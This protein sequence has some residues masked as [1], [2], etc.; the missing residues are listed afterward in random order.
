MS[1]QF[2]TEAQRMQKLANMPISEMALP[3]M[4]R[5]AGTGGAYT[6]TEKGEEILKQAKAT[7]KAPEGIKNSEIAALVFLFK[8]KKEGK[9]VQKMDYAKEKG[10]DQPAVNST[11][12]GL[13]MKEL[14][15]KEGYT[16][17]QQEPKTS[18]PRTDIS[19]ALSDLDI[20][21]SKKTLSED[22]EDFDLNAAFKSSPASHSYNDVLN[23]FT[24]YEDEDILNDFKAKFPKDKNINKIDYYKF[25]MEYIDDM[26]ASSDIK[27]NW[28]SITDDDIFEKAGL[29][30][31]K[32]TLSEKTLTMADMDFL[33]GKIG[34]NSK[35]VEEFIKK[36]KEKDID[37]EQLLNYF[38]TLIQ[39][40][41]KN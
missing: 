20:E 3:E 32:K 33:E 18:R 40:H 25:A 35:I 5:T 17:K 28:I 4:A 37:K 41:Y 22:D 21:E 26:S 39:R 36:A 1:K 12:N 7:G 16:S 24:S 38:E 13:E 6:I 11:F 34:G 2:I 29:V 30:E 9:R 31:A 14:A 19:A 8:A 23:I 10:V 27:A 15:T